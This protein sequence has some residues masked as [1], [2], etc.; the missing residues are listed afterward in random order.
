MSIDES[1]DAN[2]I[3]T[4]IIDEEAEFKTNI[5]FTE[6]MDG[7]CLTRILKKFTKGYKTQ[8]IISMISSSLTLIT[9]SL[10]YT[11]ETSGIMVSFGL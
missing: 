4:T 8:T 6:I 7:D 3:P 2:L 5:E 1:S 9:F 10:P 11:I